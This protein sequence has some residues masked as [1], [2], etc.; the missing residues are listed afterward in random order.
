MESAKCECI[1]VRWVLKAIS[2]QPTHLNNVVI[3]TIKILEIADDRIPF[4][5]G[6]NIDRRFDFNRSSQV[7]SVSKMNLGGVQQQIRGLAGSSIRAC[8]TS[9]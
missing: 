1:S 9:R 8:S 3:S 7:I 5:L 6:K 2:L 4:V